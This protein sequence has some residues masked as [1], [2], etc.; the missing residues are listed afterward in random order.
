M[1]S[2]GS[3]RLAEALQKLDRGAGSALAR[4]FGITSAAVS[5]WA[6][7]AARPGARNRAALAAIFGISAESWEIGRAHV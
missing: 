7:G 6:T 1:K 3:R 2:E 4:S 5:A